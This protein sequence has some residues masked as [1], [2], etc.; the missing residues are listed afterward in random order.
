M[1][2]LFVKTAL[3]MGALTGLAVLVFVL[4][5]HAFGL[6]PLG[7]HTFLFLPMYAMGLILGFR[8]YRTYRNGGLLGGAEAVS[9]GIIANFAASVTY[10]LLFYA[11]LAWVSPAI[12]RT[13]QA[14]VRDKLL[15][16]KEIILKDP[17][18]GQKYL[19][20]SLA[21]IPKMSVDQAA[22]EDFKKLSGMGLV[23]SIAI[24]LF[25]R[26]KQL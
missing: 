24:G 11:W 18:F 20:D 4:I 26:K 7:R 13:H 6:N 10:G 19:D 8:Y 21:A 22:W 1:K 17:D 5:I 3:T 9:M 15:T 12:L 23:M 25:F 14:A 16:D 2:N